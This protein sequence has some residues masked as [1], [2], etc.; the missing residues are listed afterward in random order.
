MDV[1]YRIAKLLTLAVGIESCLVMIGWIFGIDALTRFLP[2]EINMKFPT[3]VVFLFSAIGLYLIIRVVQYNDE[4]ARVMLPG[5][6]LFIFLIMSVL[7][8]SGLS[9]GQTGMEDLFVREQRPLYEFGAGWPA[10]P[11]EINFILFGLAELFCLFPG[12]RLYK[13]FQFFGYPVVVIGA[14]A[15]IGYTLSIPVLFYKFTPS[16]VPIAL[17]TAITFMAL[18]LG[19]ILISRIKTPP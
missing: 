16:T 2:G 3:A 1:R 18:G 14:I 8:A 10:L 15:V 4:Y 12:T 6:A 11:T 19:M 9:G 5:N 13:G 7:F 17:N